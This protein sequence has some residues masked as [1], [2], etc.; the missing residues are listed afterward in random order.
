MP[1]GALSGGACGVGRDDVGCMPV[2]VAAGPVITA[3]S[4]EDPRGRRLPAR[5]AARPRRPCA[6]VMKACLSVCGVTILVIPA[7]Q[8]VVRTMRPVLCRSSRARPRPGT[9]VLRSVPDGQVDRTGGPWCQRD[10]HHL[11]VLTGDVE[12]PVP[13]LQAQVL[14]IGAGGLRYPQP[15]QREQRDQRMPSRRPKPR[16]R[17]GARRAPCG[18]VR[19][20]GTRSPPADGAHAAGGDPIALL[21]PRTR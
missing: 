4:S 1:A 15:V 17:P 5:P 11:A 3:S 6:A 21:G 10:G 18:P 20:R 9:A 13:A 7:R 12:S 19:Q 8:A 16:W 14:D 2:K